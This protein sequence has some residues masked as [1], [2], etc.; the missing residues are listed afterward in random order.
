MIYFGGNEMFYDERI[1]YVKGTIAR[2]ALVL[3]LFLSLV[4]G[5]IHLAN[6]NNIPPLFAT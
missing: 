6:S 3:S 5:G 2:N 1:E 4:L